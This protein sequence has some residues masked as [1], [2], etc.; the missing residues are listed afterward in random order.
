M[1]NSGT[2]KKSLLFDLRMIQKRSDQEVCS[3]ASI[4]TLHSRNVRNI[5]LSRVCETTCGGRETHML[6]GRCQAPAD[7]QTR[8]LCCEHLA[9]TAGGPPSASAAL[10]SVNSCSL[11]AFFVH[12]KLW[13]LVFQCITKSISCTLTMCQAL[14]A[15]FPRNM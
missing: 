15:S 12:F 11:K 3:R 9:G 13:M 2:W 1:A 7:A 8:S 10:S 6:C 5:F 14:H 4:S